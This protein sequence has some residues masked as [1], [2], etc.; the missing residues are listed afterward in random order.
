M[1]IITPKLE[2]SDEETFEKDIFGRSEFGQSLLNLACQSN[3]ELV[4]SLDGRWGEGKTTFV[5][6]WK[7]L[8]KKNDIPCVYIDAFAND[9]I[10][11]AFISV[12]SSITSYIDKNAANKDERKKKEFK[13]KTKSVGVQILSWTAKVGIKAASLGAIKNSDINELKDIKNEISGSLSNVVGKFVEERLASHDKDVE[14]LESFKTILSEMPSLL[15]KNGDK[16]LIII[17]DELD[18]CK[19]TYAVELIEKVKHLFSVKNVVFVLV[20]HMKQ[21][22]ESVKSVYGQNID[23]RTY[24]QKFINVEMTLPKSLGNTQ[25]NDISKYNK[26][27]FELH[28]I[29]SLDGKD[30]LIDSI[31]VLAIHFNLSLRQLEKVYTN[32]AILYASSSETDRRLTPIIA[33]LSVIKV[34]DTS[35]YGMLLHKGLTYDELFAKTSL[36]EQGSNVGEKRKLAFIASWLRYC[37]ISDEEFEALDQNDRVKG[38]GN[39]FSNNNIEAKNI[40]PLYIQKLSMFTVV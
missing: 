23:A 36:S 33:F 24:L 34:V 40:I 13:E 25:V 4:I 14:T 26:R 8:L 6:M 2:L 20:M 1:K 38:F 39:Y 21:L 31:E 11:D 16:P 19:P 15:S 18:R 12:A 17:I 28:E 37:L 10:D 30:N 7:N 5:R 35:I 27:L 22:E 3:D 32:I 29:E 9:Y